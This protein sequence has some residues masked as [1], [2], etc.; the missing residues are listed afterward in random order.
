M[1]STEEQNA[2]GYDSE[3]TDDTGL[4]NLRARWYDPGKGRFIS[5]DTWGGDYQVPQ[6]LNSWE[7]TDNNPINYSD[8]TGNITQK[9]QDQAEK[10]LNWLKTYD[11]TLIIDWGWKFS[12]IPVPAPSDSSEKLL[13]NECWMEGDWSIK[14][15][16]TLQIGVS[17]LS[18]AMGGS[19]RFNYNIGGVTISQ[20]DI[21]NDR[22]L[23]NLHQVRFTSSS[24]SIDQWT[25][26]HELSHAWD[27]NFDWA[28]SN[29]LVAYTGGYVDIV[30]SKI[31]KLKGVCKNKPWEK[32]CNSA[33]YY[34]GGN[35][36]KGSDMGF[37]PKEDFAESVTTYI[38]PNE[39]LQ[40]I[41]NLMPKEYQN[42][43]S[44]GD[45]KKELR[46]IFVKGLFDGT[47]SY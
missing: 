31:D 23:T 26:V 19:E 33:G 24:T 43:Y 38:Y 1:S 36:P 7:Y 30:Q 40:D 11:I 10:I 14:E 3:Q 45:Y 20:E 37:N 35:P 46:G 41:A 5:A 12:P 39:A 18:K 47:I 13:Q 21:G 2:Y 29:K 32:G 6:S 4:V 44:Y 42:L 9:E 8:P 34:Y 27:A 25:V 16:R 28:L 22:G 15:L 17:D